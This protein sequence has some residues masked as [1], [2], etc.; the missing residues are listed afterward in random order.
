MGEGNRMYTVKRTQYEIDQMLDM[1]QRWE[2]HG[3]SAVPGQSYEQGVMAGI[4]WVLGERECDPIDVGP[5]AFR[6]G[7]EYDSEDEG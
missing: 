3:G 2:E 6:E 7:P 4:Q 1:A 5:G